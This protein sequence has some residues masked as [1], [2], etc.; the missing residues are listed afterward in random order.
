MRAWLRMT[1]SLLALVPAL[2]FGVGAVAAPLRVVILPIVVHSAVDDANYVSA[3]LADMLSSRLE[4]LGELTVLRRD[5]GGTIELDEALE[6]VEGSGA[7]YV[8]YGAFTQFGDGASLDIH[9]APTASLEEAATRR[10]IF[11]QSGNVSE[12]IPKLDELVDRVAFFLNRPSSAPAPGGPSN[13]TAAAANPAAAPGEL[14]VL[15]GRIDALE[16][17]VYG[18]GEQATD[19]A[20]IPSVPEATPES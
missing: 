16:Q 3:G 10:R 11:I 17:A 5:E 8:I 7:D 14:E 9:C 19:A 4:Q 20:A 6:R 15:R 2:L 13:P 1:I 18:L 12:I